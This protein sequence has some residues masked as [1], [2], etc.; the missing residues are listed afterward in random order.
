MK[1]LTNI[2]AA[3]LLFAAAGV[4]AVNAAS[5]TPA[6]DGPNTIQNPLN[7]LFSDIG[8]IFSTLS[9][10]IIP[11]ATL[12]F[13]AMIIYGGFTYLTAAGSDEKVAQAKKILTF[14]V[15]GFIIILVAPVVVGIISALFGV[16]LIGG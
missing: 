3:I 16:Q 4:S 1:V 14:A 5:P 11:V 10:F 15:I 9:A 12:A 8:S 2:L 7:S 6:T 13:L